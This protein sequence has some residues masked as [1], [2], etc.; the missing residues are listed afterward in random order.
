MEAIAKFKSKHRLTLRCTRS[1]PAGLLRVSLSLGR[2]GGIMSLI[3]CPDCG[4][5]ISQ[6]APICIGCG[7]PMKQ[8]TG[9]PDTESPTGRAT[10]S[11]AT[12]SAPD[13]YQKEV[14][15]T[16]ASEAGSARVKRSL[17]SWKSLGIAV[18][19]S[20]VI[21]I[22][23]AGATGGKAP[24]NMTWTVIWLYLTIE[25]WKYWKWK[26]LIPYPM[27]IVASSLLGLM[28]VG[29]N[30]YNISWAHVVTKVGLNIGGLIV[31]YVALHKAQTKAK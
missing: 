18:A 11:T 19:I 13:H 29:D 2:I 16:V 17:W 7:R 12:K 21:I 9:M 26:A 20:F 5:E 8:S 4:K 14:E 24:K 23:A 27:F 3:K 6:E 15:P 1:Q 22:I 31:F 28:M 10:P 30:P 25:G